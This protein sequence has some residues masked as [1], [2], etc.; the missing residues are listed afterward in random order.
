MNC[1][2]LVILHRII[3]FLSDIVVTKAEAGFTVVKCLIAKL[4]KLRY[5][6]NI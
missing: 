1:Q 6:K 4:L 5:S 2:W 3:L